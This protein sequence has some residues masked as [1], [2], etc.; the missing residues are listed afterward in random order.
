VSEATA[1]PHEFDRPTGPARDPLLR[2]DW[3]NQMALVWVLTRREI[4]D[5]MRD[6]RL[7]VP[8]TLLTLVF[9]VILNLAANFTL[10]WVR[11]YNAAVIG[12]QAIP[13]MLLV[14]GFF[15]ISFSL[16]IA[17]ETFV[18]EKERKSLEP[19]LA[20]PL[21]NTQLYL[22]KTLAAL[23][24]PV[25]ASFLG[26][27]V[28]FVSLMLSVQYRPSPTLVVQILGLTTAEALVMVSSAVIISSQTTSV[29]AANLLA[30]FV[31]L[32]MAFLVQGE[33]LIMFWGRY[34]ALW[35]VLM[36]LI[37]SDVMLV[38]MG[39]RVFNR[40]ELLGRDIDR[41][42]LRRG[43]QLL[44]RFFLDPPLAEGSGR[45]A[46]VRGRGWLARLYRQDV[47]Q[48]LRLNGPATAVVVVALTGAAL[49]GVGVAL[50]FP[51]PEGVIRLDEIGRETFAQFEGTHLLPSLNTWTIFTHNVRSLLMAGALALVSFGALAIVLLMAPIGII[52]FATAQAALAGYNPLLFLGVFIL[53]HGFLELPAAI[54]ATAA[55]VRLGIGVVAPPAGM[56]ISQSCL[57]GLAHFAKLFLFVVLPLLAVAALIEV[58]VTPELVLAVYGR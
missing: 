18:G 43:W 1:H 5:T 13:F 17:L 24:P 28:Y 49:L 55:A 22:G 21:S 29:R 39:I 53:P 9:P 32:P 44:K 33:A 11:Q 3:R 48:M 37:V 42:N 6:W 50:R 52:G 30:S 4:R 15:P 12:E 57:R 51:L 10:N 25:V 8:I 58:T 2:E 54:L 47:P 41:I 46:G 16:V 31:I 19:L 27:G 45:A 26:I 14:V 56:T 36:A 35:F 7:V 23:I 34:E 20:T 38:R 40:E